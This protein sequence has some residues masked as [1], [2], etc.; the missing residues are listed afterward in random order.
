MTLCYVPRSLMASDIDECQVLKVV[1]LWV[2]RV[3]INSL[4]VVS[5]ARV[6]KVTSAIRVTSV[7]SVALLITLSAVVSMRESARSSHFS[8]LPYRQLHSVSVLPYRLFAPY[9]QSPCSHQIYIVSGFIH[10]VSGFIHTVSGFPYIQSAGSHQTAI[11]SG[12]PSDSHS[13]RVPI[14]QP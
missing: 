14:R 6:L 8:V 9:I 10:T 4:G 2:N 12:F 13:L 3:N 7:I 11:V 5:V 1:V